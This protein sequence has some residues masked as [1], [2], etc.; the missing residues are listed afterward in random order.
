MLW[1]D[2][3]L[4]SQTGNLSHHAQLEL[5]WTVSLHE[6]TD[7]IVDSLPCDSQFTLAPLQ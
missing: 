7:Q 4:V 6:Q 3:S 5:K 2:D 1:T